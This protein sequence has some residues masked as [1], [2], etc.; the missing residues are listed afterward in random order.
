MSAGSFWVIAFFVFINNGCSLLG[1][2]DRSVGAVA[3][4]IESRTEIAN[5]ITLQ[6]AQKAN[7][8]GRPPDDGQEPSTIF[9]TLRA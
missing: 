8:G 6:R 1:C 5:A 3:R 4:G 7:A 9:L 2:G